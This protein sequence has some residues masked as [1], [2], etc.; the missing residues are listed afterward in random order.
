MINGE[1]DATPPAT[2]VSGASSGFL[3]EI[4]VTV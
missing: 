1:F 2:Y 4:A 3:P